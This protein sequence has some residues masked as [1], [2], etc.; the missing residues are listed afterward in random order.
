MNNN[1]S[2]FASFAALRETG[3]MLSATA[4]PM[5]LMLLWAKTPGAGLKGLPS[6]KDAS[7]DF[8]VNQTAKI[9]KVLCP[10]ISD[11]VTK[12]IERLPP[13]AIE[14][15]RRALLTALERQSD[16]E[17]IAEAI[18]EYSIPEVWIA[19]RA[20]AVLEAALG[21]TDAA[22]IRC[23]FAY[24]LR[25]AWALSK[26]CAV[27]LDVDQTDLAHV[28][29]M[30]AMACER[31]LT[32][33]INTIAAVAAEQRSDGWDHGL[34]LPP[35]GMRLPPRSAYDA[36]G[37]E[38]QSTEGFG[39]RWGAELG[40]NRNIVVVGNGFLFRTS[41][42]DAA[43]KQELVYGRGL[44]AV[45][46]LPRGTFPTTAIG[47]SAMIFGGT[48]S[49]RKP[50]HHNVRFID[51]SDL[52][53]LDAAEVAVLIDHKRKHPLCADV[54]FEELAASGFNL[55]VDRY[56]LDAETIRT[57]SLLEK[58]QTVALS[59][60]ADIR[61]P[62]AL[63]RESGK[64]ESMEIR[65]AM[66][67]DINNGRLGL[68][69]K[70]SKI[71]ATALTKI[72][73]AILKP[74]DILLS[75][76][77]TI[78]KAALVTEVPIAESKPIPVVPGQSFVI[79]RLRKGSLIHDPK[80]LLSYLRSPVAQSILKGMAGGT[81]IPNVA[82]GP[83]KDMAVP[84]PCA[85][86]Q[87]KLVKRFHKWQEIQTEIERLQEKMKDAEEALFSIALGNNEQEEGAHADR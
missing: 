39:A 9:T 42:K 84:I 15:F 23:A 78:G 85:E 13:S 70:L 57:R 2:I 53:A 63:P 22:S 81:T 25:P 3:L 47:V 87:E 20:A 51:A 33:R 61:R 6:L 60:L 75:I 86:A 64:G 11:D 4:L 31:R 30:L 80:V 48:E 66:L 62:Q 12:T 35:I 65:E 52:V 56:V 28:M 74:G 44:E 58:Q 59:D 19:G 26:R 43:L 71:P 79:L 17:E 73:S 72:E 38:T 40:R 29:S 45:I 1:P 7:A 67:A 49:V 36:A 69:E 46:A 41:S 18:I 5:S 34:V 8:V 50:R 37:A 21:A 77:G 83:L 82:M 27:E 14:T 76:K 68:P 24:A 10:A 32:V 54:S 55:S 16:C